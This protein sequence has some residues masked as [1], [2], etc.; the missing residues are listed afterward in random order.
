MAA[1]GVSVLPGYFQDWGTKKVG[2]VEVYGPTLYAAGGQTITA[3][4]FGLGG[5][6]AIITL[7]R[8]LSGTYFPAQV[9]PLPIDAAPSV[10]LGA[11]ASFKVP[12]F[13]VATGAEAGAIDLSTEIIRLLVIGV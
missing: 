5:I 2:I 1:Q 11:A 3:S 8:T 9:Q 13:V 10:P 4:Q 6:E 7:G 12:W